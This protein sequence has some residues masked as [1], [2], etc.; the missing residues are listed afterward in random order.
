MSLIW[1][2]DT[3]GLAIFGISFISA[4]AY[5]LYIYVI[6]ITG[7][8]FASQ[9]A[10]VVTLAGVFWGMAIFKEEHS[11]WVWASLL[12]MMAGL[13]LVTPRR[14]SAELSSSVGLGLENKNSS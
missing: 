1:P 11:L 14:K 4:I 8:L 7:P 2:P 9:S 12:S 10:Y 3:A 5:T 13:A 6:K